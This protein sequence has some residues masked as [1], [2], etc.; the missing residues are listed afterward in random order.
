MTK[1]EE[2]NIIITEREYLEA[3]AAEYKGKI[4]KIEV[5]MNNLLKSEYDAIKYESIMDD[6]KSEIFDI[7]QKIKELRVE[8]KQLN[9]RLKNLISQ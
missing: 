9:I 2:I 7:E 6:Y 1:Q 4:R 8:Y 5:S 3:D